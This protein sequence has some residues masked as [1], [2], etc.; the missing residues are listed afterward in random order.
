MSN[1]V[2][3][4]ADKGTFPDIRSIQP[5]LATPT[6]VVGEPTAGRRVK[7]TAQEYVGTNVFHALY[8]PT[9]WKPDGDRKYP[10][11][12]EYA[13]NGPYRGPH[14]DVCTGK[15]EDC[16]LGYG[17]S[18]GRQV[19]WVCLPYISQD[20]QSNQLRWFGNVKATVEYCKTVVPQVCEEW[21]GDPDAIF[22]AGFSR[23]SIACNYIGLHDDE[24]AKLWRG[25]ICHSHY[26]GVYKWDFPKSDRK[27]ALK[28][29]NRLDGRA[30]FISHEKSVD[31]TKEYLAQVA[32]HGNFTF[33][34][35][36]FRNHTDLWTLRDVPERR[37]VRIWLDQ[38]LRKPVVAE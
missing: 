22:I 38:I 37:A 31:A 16:N 24:I 27:S 35:L 10:V 34:K 1:A 2:A 12:V 21:N 29:L 19:I 5:D 14:G 25:F 3:N 4:S 33:Q 30:Q 9:D 23:G 26:D 15:V 32:R 11:I 6:M 13:G 20:K 7:V 36:A 17:I 28:R 18:A 8:L